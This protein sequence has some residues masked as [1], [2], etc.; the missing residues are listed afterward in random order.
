MEK[1]FKY[2]WAIVGIIG[3]ITVFFAVQLPQAELDN[4]HTRF[5]PDDNLAM[6]TS[7]YMGN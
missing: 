2:P 6:V 4:N 3:V 7:N 1:I 5:L